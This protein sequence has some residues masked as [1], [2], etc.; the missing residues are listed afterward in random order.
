VVEVRCQFGNR[1]RGTFAVG[2][3]Y[4]GTGDDTADREDLLHAVVKCSGDSMVVKC[5]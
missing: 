1:K 5:N 2:R 3:R 4:Q